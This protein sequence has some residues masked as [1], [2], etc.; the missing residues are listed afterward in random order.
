MEFKNNTQCIEVVME[1]K[2][3]GDIGNILRINTLNRMFELNK[4]VEVD[5]KVLFDLMNSL[6]SYS[7]SVDCEIEEKGKLETVFLSSIYHHYLL[8]MIEL[9]TYLGYNYTEVL[10]E[11]ENK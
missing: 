1:L 11:I 10:K 4:K 9:E 5:N 6:I 8:L 7:E 3:L 2:R